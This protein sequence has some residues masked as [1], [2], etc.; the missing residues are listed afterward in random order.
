MYRVHCFGR[1]AIERGDGEV[2]ALRSRKHTGLLLYLLAHRGRQHTRDR[3]AGLFWES[4]HRRA[5]HSLSQALYDIRNRLPGLELARNSSRVGLAGNG[6]VFDADELEAAVREHDLRR[7][8]RLY[9]GEF[10]PDLDDVGNPDFERWLERERVRFRRLAEVALYRHVRECAEG[11]RWGEMCTTA[12]RLLEMNPLS[13]KA[14]RALLRGL[15]LQG[16]GDAALE[17]FRDV[18]PE[19]EAE[20]PGGVS[21]ETRELV[22]RIR[23]KPS[24]PA[25]V[26]EAPRPPFVGRT[27][28]FGVLR[29]ALEDTVKGEGGLVLVR[30]E[31]GMGK[32]RLL[33]E[34]RDAATLEGVRVLESRCYSAETDVPYGPV[35]EGLEEVAAT[36]AA[37]DTAGNGYHLLGHLFPGSFPPPSDHQGFSGAG[38]GRR[39]LY[40]ETADLLRRGCREAPVVWLVEDVHWIDASS[41]SLLHYLVRRAADQAFLLVAT[42][43]TDEHPSEAARELLGAG[44]SASVASTS[45][46]LPPLALEEVGELAREVGGRPL[47]ERARA[48]LHRLSGGNPFYALEILR[49]LPEAPG[50]R[51]EADIFSGGDG[52]AAESDVPMPPAPDSPPSW[53]DGTGSE[54]APTGRVP[55]SDRLREL[56]E[57]RLRGLEPRTYRLLEAAAVAGRYATP[58]LTARAAGLSLKEAAAR[59]RALYERGLLEDG[60]G[61]VGFPHDIT[62]NFVY[63]SMG[64]LPR[65]ALHLVVG[66]ILSEHGGDVGDATLARH[67]QRGGDPA[68]AYAYAVRAARDA[69]GRYA[70]REAAA[71]ARL[72]LVVSEGGGQRAGAL[73]LLARAELAAGRLGMAEDHA[74]ELLAMDVLTPEEEA[75]LRLRLSRALVG[76][77]R[78]EEADR[79]LD[80]VGGLTPR[81]ADGRRDEVALRRLYLNLKGAIHRQDDPEIRQA[82]GRLEE[83]ER[84]DDFEALSPACQALVL[85][86]LAAYETFHRSSNAA[87]SYFREHPIPVEEL[88]PDLRLQFH[89]LKGL[90]AY[91]AAEWDEAEAENRVILQLAREYNDLLY[92]GS[93]LNNLMAIAYGRGRWAE[94]EERYD[95][96]RSVVQ[97]LPQEGGT[98]RLSMY[99]E[100]NG[101]DVSLFASNSREA[102]DRYAN[103]LRFSRVLKDPSE[104]ARTL[105]MQGV[106][107]LSQGTRD[108]VG[109]TWVALSKIKKTGVRAVQ[110]G[111]RIAWFEA[112]MLWLHEERDEAIRRL[113]EA[114]EDERELDHVGALY[115]AWLKEMLSASDEG[116]DLDDLIKTSPVAARLRAAEAGWFVRFLRRWWL[117]ARQGG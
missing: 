26:A 51:L 110:S 57:R 84:A 10:A 11:G 20:L 105:A 76:Q 32:T 62:R 65:A 22:E 100:Q 117:A 7:A 54:E 53:P 71:M 14:H 46:T 52:P 24:A 89:T 90:C 45:V 29:S 99:I 28:E 91:R 55:I 16:E 41:A 48:T 68:R 42:V 23:R 37:E 61:R 19:L 75:E 8:V 21:P 5:R 85:T 34:F 1:L 64:E 86:G 39:R 103:A 12:M 25:R 77:E 101:G 4:D 82:V 98:I 93:A 87:R 94:A 2:V 27:Q 59:A 13:E 30:G 115:V 92:R 88:P 73:Q 67:F 114:W 72:A 43:R 63:R 44:E 78:W 83:Y 17:H 104:T 66:E 58:V 107:L 35:A 112:S 102:L 81:V 69:E 38:G 47:P 97:A 33:E 79:H 49:L 108:A 40:E 113:D 70:H 6:V 36:V 18:E 15:W 3:L 109:S 80:R 9:D 111:S 74:Q 56:L 50:G 96:A 31:A 95:E 106:A 116:R 60:D